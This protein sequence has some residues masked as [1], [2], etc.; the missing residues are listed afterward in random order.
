LRNLPLGEYTRKV[1]EHI[2]HPQNLVSSNGSF[3]P[4]FFSP[5]VG[6]GE[7]RYH[8]IWYHSLNRQTVTWVANRDDPVAYSSGVF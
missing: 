1:S 4:G 6:S 5:G 7:K 3:E 2:T 8:G